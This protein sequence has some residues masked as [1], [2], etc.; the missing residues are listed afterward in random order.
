MDPVRA[1]LALAGLLI[2]ATGASAAGLAS[3]RR[4]LLSV[5]KQLEATR[6]EIDQYRKLEDSLGQDLAKL[7]DRDVQARRRMGDLERS[8]RAAEARRAELRGKLSALGQATGFWRSSLDADVRL[9]ADARYSDNPAYGT[10]AVWADAL[11]RAAAVEK[12]QMLG[13]LTGYSR[14][15]RQAAEASRRRARELLDRS[16][17]AKRQ[18]QD[19][20]QKIQAT[21]AAIAD[22]QE[23]R[24]KA[25][26]R[27]QELEDSARALT[28]L[29]RSFGRRRHG[30]KAP[31]SLSVPPHS[32]PWPARGQVVRAFGRQRNEELGTWMINQGILLATAPA[33]PVTPVEKGRVIFAGPFR[34][35]GQ[36]LILDHG[37]NFFSI[38]GDLGRILIAKGAEVRP[39]EIIA[40]AG[41]SGAGGK[42]YLEIRRGT[43]ALDPAAWLEQH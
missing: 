10:G 38:Y 7:S 2:W 13:R 23:R 31:A 30:R 16:R 18:Q 26:R 4:Q 40:R 34:S 39:G 1:S 42:V 41:G 17:L 20:Q 24:A 22:A 27:A 36:V 35:Y 14:K 28:R 33:A 32:L 12:A 19:G 29:I 5:Q 15:A 9:Y 25:V 3:K 11:R 6:R 37:N 21:K 8:L 43:E